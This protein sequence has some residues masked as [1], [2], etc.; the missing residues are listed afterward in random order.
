MEAARQ[1]V[2]E[3]MAEES[4]S[5]KSKKRRKSTGKGRGN[6]YSG[7]ES[8][9]SDSDI[10]SGHRGLRKR[11][12]RDDVDNMAR[13]SSTAYRDR[14]KERR[15]GNTGFEDVTAYL[16]KNID[17]GTTSLQESAPSSGGLQAL[18]SATTA[19]SA[20]GGSLEARKI[21]KN[22]QK[23]HRK[24]MNLGDR[25]LR[26][27]QRQA[28]TLAPKSTHRNRVRKLKTNSNLASKRVSRRTR[29]L[30][31]NLVYHFDAT[32]EL[33]PQ[34]Y[35]DS[36]V[37][38]TEVLHNSKMSEDY[39]RKT[40]REANPK[41]ESELIDIVC[42]GFA[43]AKIALED[44]HPV[45]LK[46]Q[47]RKKEQELEIA[48]D[49]IEQ[50]L[51]E[52]VSSKSPRQ[53]ASGDPGGNKDVPVDDKNEEISDGDIF[54]DVG[55]YRPSDHEG[56]GNDADD[57]QCEDLS[58]QEQD[59]DFQDQAKDVGPA[60]LSDVQ[61]TATFQFDMGSM[62]YY[63]KP[64]VGVEKVIVVKLHPGKPAP[65]ESLTVYVLESYDKRRLKRELN[66]L[67]NSK[68]LSMS[69]PDDKSLLLPKQF[70]DRCSVVRANDKRS[71]IGIELDMCD[72]ILES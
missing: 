64:G 12:K 5:K 23:R 54:E 14:A 9:G 16:S 34:T 8:A 51:A 32:P 37:I 2:R 43:R 7:S 56:E 50:R 49:A 4:R 41:L 15:S 58:M 30:E 48:K 53:H 3:A 66:L 45:I 31:G 52:Q 29:W 10:D 24:K 20:E 69:P 25:I 26:V 71:W 72:Y 40:D 65:T 47:L 67:P 13:V 33:D 19:Y 6:S 38:P 63:T 1:A 18:G 11:L 42:H 70:R 35:R 68:K 46:Q 28:E 27:L 61:Y 62:L 36:M 55:E 21:K 17:Y 59:G 39:V 60:S 22:A 44:L 57:H